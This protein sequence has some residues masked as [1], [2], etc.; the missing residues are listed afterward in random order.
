[1]YC[2]NCGAKNEDDSVFCT[3]CGMPLAEPEETAAEQNAAEQ[4]ETPCEGTCAEQN[5]EQNAPQ[6]APRNTEP[7]TAQTAQSSAEPNAAPSV[8]VF[9]LKYFW[10]A[11]KRVILA[12]AAALG[13][14]LLIIALASG[15][16]WK[17]TVKGY[18]GSIKRGDFAAASRYLPNEP[19]EH[20]LE[21][22]GMS[23]AEYKEKVAES[24]DNLKDNLEDRLF[25]YYDMTLK[26]YLKGF[27][28]EIVRSKKCSDAEI[29]Q[30]DKKY[31][32]DY[33]T[34]RG[35]IKDA[36]DVKVRLKYELDDEEKETVTI[37]LVK[38]GG[39]WYLSQYDSMSVQ[40]LLLNP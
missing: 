18:L 23:R 39:K 8:A 14:L 37:K 29:Q 20:M 6:N 7:Y 5:A 10:E 1:M 30:L 33:D 22:S 13:C 9:R 25:D 11:H 31:S 12:A 4:P 35:Y 2:T 28:Y 17:A 3:S 34:K 21:E 40:N 24:F 15:R 32:K 36:M 16:S 38:I 27:S 26:E 19:I